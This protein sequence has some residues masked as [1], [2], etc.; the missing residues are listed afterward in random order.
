MRSVP[1]CPGYPGADLSCIFLQVALLD[2]Q[3]G[4]E[5]MSS[6]LMRRGLT[7]KPVIPGQTI[8]R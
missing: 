8:S 1:K 4:V 2:I 6:S 3:I 5:R 7:V